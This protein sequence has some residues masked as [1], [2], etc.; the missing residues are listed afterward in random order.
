MDVLSFNRAGVLVSEG[1]QSTQIFVADLSPFSGRSITQLVIQD[2][3]DA[4]SGFGGGV[5]PV[6]GFDL[7][8]IGIGAI[9]GIGRVEIA[10]QLSLGSAEIAFSAGAIAQESAGR[11]RNDVKLNGLSTDG[12]IQ[13][14]EVGLDQFGVDGELGFLSLGHRGE[15]IFTF[16]EPIF[17]TAGEQLIIGEWGVGGETIGSPD[18]ASA[19]VLAAFTDPIPGS[20]GGGPINANGDGLS[21]AE[22]IVTAFLYQAGLGRVPDAPGLNFW[23]G[24]REAGVS[25]IEIAAAFLTSPEFLNN[26]G[27]VDQFTDRQFV[28]ILFRNILGREGDEGGIAFWASALAEDRI[29]P[30]ALL[31]AFASSPENTSDDE[32][33]NGVFKRDGLWIVPESPG[34]GLVVDNVEVDDTDPEA[35]IFIG[36]EAPNRIDG[37]DQPDVIYG[38]EGND[39]VRG[40]A[41]DDS[42]FG[43]TGQ[44][45]LRGGSGEDTLYGD[46][47]A[48]TVRGGYGNDTLF[49][50]PGADLLSGDGGDDYIVS[51]TGDDRIEFTAGFDVIW[52]GSGTDT[53]I[54]QVP[55]SQADI[56]TTDEGAIL[57]TLPDGGTAVL[58]DVERLQFTDQIVAANLDDFVLG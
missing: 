14:V 43:W 51:D 24:Q 8:G 25:A 38:N 29:E 27:D 30:D 9:S 32:I 54:F 33:I 52:G 20:D 1:G 46:D 55:L 21:R 16:A 41:G 12:T 49:S 47:G 39:T 45:V 48:D 28:E 53:V 26:Y 57:V 37:T 31:L 50:G 10:S 42:L 7:D 17:A 18:T 34:A 56:R 15:I 5:G 4:G 19:T 13:R 35:L 23:I 11:D 40:F 3:T 36:G 44:D 2:N 22:A 58:G 6:T